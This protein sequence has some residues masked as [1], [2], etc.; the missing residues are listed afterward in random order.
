MGAGELVPAAQQLA[1][2]LT[3]AGVPAV[4]DPAVA[5]VRRPCVLVAPPTVDY[6]EQLT[7]WRLVALA[8]ASSG[9][10]AAL[11]QLDELVAGVVGSGL[12]IERAEPGSY[13]LTEAGAVPAYVLRM[14]T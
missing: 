14:T 9:S 7:T 5:D 4:V 2:R 8:A 11:Q 10:L 3:A 1:D 6:T 13:A 12:P